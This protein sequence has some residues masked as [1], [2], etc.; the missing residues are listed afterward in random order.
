[1][2]VFAKSSSYVRARLDDVDKALAAAERDLADAALDSEL[3]GD[4]RA[5]AASAEIA[6]LQVRRRSLEAALRG[7]VA[8]ERVAEHEKDHRERQARLRALR[9]HW[10]VSS[11]TAARCRTRSRR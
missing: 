2:A 4:D 11:V 5:D 10:R 1:M 7:A 3:K 9:A 6:R 8:R